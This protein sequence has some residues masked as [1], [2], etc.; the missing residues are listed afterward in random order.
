MKEYES[1][2]AFGRAKSRGPNVQQVRC[3]LQ[4]K[5]GRV[6][7]DGCMLSFLFA[8]EESAALGYRVITKT[9]WLDKLRVRPLQ[10]FERHPGCLRNLS[11]T[12][13]E[14]NLCRKRKGFHEN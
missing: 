1:A 9:V 11:S 4:W 13:A 6:N 12:G 2:A 10:S 14:R 8:V 3:N 7:A 5:G